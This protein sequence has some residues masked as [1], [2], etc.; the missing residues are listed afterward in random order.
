MR[1][2][3]IKDSAELYQVAN[4]GA[5][6][7]GINERGHV[8]VTP[9][10]PE[11][12]AIDLYELIP[13]LQD[14]G[15][16]MPLLARF[17][18]IVASRV[19]GL[20]KVFAK[21]IGDYAYEGRFRGVYPIKV[22]QQRHVVEE[23]VRFGAPHRIGLEVGSKPE[24][25]T[26]LALLDTPGAL[27]VCNGYK[28]RAYIETALLAQRL[29]RTPI[30]VI[31]RFPELDLV[32]RV[33]RELG[34]RPHIGVR[35][36]LTTK[37]I[38]KWADSSGERSKFGLSAAEIVEAV[39]RLRADKMLDCLELLH[40]HIGSQIT[41]I[42]A[43]KDALREACRIF[44]G[45]HAMGARPHLLDVGGGLGVDYDGSQTNF[46]SS[47]NYSMQ[48][49]ANDV[50]SSVQEA[51]DET[52]V[53]H[54][55]I[56]TEAGRAMVAHHSVLIFDVLGVSE[57]RL[58]ETPEAATADDPR[59]V[60]DLYEI[61]STL[62]RKNPLE[63][64]HDLLQLKEEAGTLFALGYLDLRARARVEKLFQAS[65]EKLLRIVREL[66]QVPEE[67]ADLEKT[68]SDT[69]YCNFSMFQSLPDHWG[70]KQ[71]FPVMPIHRLEHEPTR[72]G[73]LADLTCDSDGKIGEFIDQHD[74]RTTLELHALNGA[75]YYIGVFLVG[76][77]QEI[78]GDL[79]NLF[80]DTH[81]VHVRVDDEGKTLIE[82]VV[83][84]DKVREVLDY[85]EYEGAELV[86][87]V[88][89]TANALV[90]RGELSHEEAQLLLKR[91]E[92]AL[93]ETTYLSRE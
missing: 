73:I 45:L 65:C 78:L 74:V 15:L 36:R 3:S 2:W 77:Y 82:H 41:A 72:R 10:G 14:R 20:S 8:Q 67:F 83:Q 21:A 4:W 42:R 68:L 85:V 60:Q 59:V 86:A 49:Y 75:P 27:L 93:E 71:L 6:F 23:I 9:R 92:Q 80:G 19:R 52:G 35:A 63:G 47:M 29:G 66:P 1:N 50:V 79:H 61:W 28:D 69:Y 11:G 48:E 43:H 84:G 18:D 56:V 24:L 12:P 30:L 39:D 91:Y 31:D 46:H 70:F 90:E 40:F 58:A 89:Q 44:V 33:S 25:I 76:A 87:K 62:S 17:S 37:S 64:W 13:V 88:E 54:P 51:C 26:A 38:G 16:R 34:V 81:A 32:I 53:P 22:N 5:G 55:D 7:F 57:L